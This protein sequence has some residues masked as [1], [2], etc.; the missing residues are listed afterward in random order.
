MMVISSGGQSLIKSHDP[1]H[2]QIN[3]WDWRDS[4]GLDFELVLRQETHTDIILLKCPTSSV[5]QMHCDSWD[6]RMKRAWEQPLY[7]IQI[8]SNTWPLRLVVRVDTGEVIEVRLLLDVNDGDYVKW[9]TVRE[10][11]HSSGMINFINIILVR[12]LLTL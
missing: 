5:H 11:L 2:D 3:L 1:H 6:I 12:R 10:E 8:E 7:F 9:K 4:S